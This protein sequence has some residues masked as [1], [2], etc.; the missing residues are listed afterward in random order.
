MLTAAGQRTPRPTTSSPPPWRHVLRTLVVVALLCAGLTATPP[1]PAGASEPARAF[2]HFDG[3]ATGFSW[4]NSYLLALLSKYAYNPDVGAAGN[5]QFEDKFKETVQPLGLCDDLDTCPVDFV[6]EPST[7]TEVVK[8]ETADAVIITFRGTEGWQEGPEDLTDVAVDGNILTT[9]SGIHQGFAD[10]ADSVHAEV[11]AWAAQARADGKRIWL[12]GHSLGG[13]VAEVTGLYLEAPHL[14]Q[15]PS[16]AS[17]IQVQNVYPYGAPRVYSRFPNSTAFNAHVANVPTQRWVNGFDPVPH[18]PPSQLLIP[19]GTLYTHVG[20]NDHAS[21]ITKLNNIFDCT[22]YIDDTELLVGGNPWDHDIGRYSVRIYNLMPPSVRDLEGMPEPP[23]QSESDQVLPCDEDATPPPPQ[24]LRISVSDSKITEGDE[25]TLSVQFLEDEAP[26]SGSP[27]TL[28]LDWGEG[29]IRL[30][31]A[32]GD[33]ELT[34]TYAD[35]AT[36]G[37]SSDAYRIRVWDVTAGSRTETTLV[38]VLNAEPE[39]TSFVTPEAVDEGETFTVSGTFTDVG[40][41]DTHRV[42]LQW[43]DG[44]SEWLT[45]PFGDRTF[46]ASHAYAEGSGGTETVVALVLDDDGDHDPSG[47]VIRV[48]NVA[49][50]IET[51]RLGATTIDEGGTAAIRGTFSDPS[52]LDSHTVSVDWGDGT[53]PTVL[54]VAADADHRQFVARHDYPDD[55]P[56]GTAE[57]VYP[58]TVTVTDDDGGTTSDALDL[59]VAN[60]APSL[61]A[62]LDE[63]TIDEHEVATVRGTVTDAGVADTHR[64]VVDWGD[65]ALGTT[66]VTPGSD[67]SFEASARYGD[68]GTFPVSVTV[69]DDDTG[70]D[71]E[72]LTLTVDNVAPTATIDETGTILGDG[73]DG[74]GVLE[75]PTLV[76]RAGGSTGFS[77]RVTD[78]GSDDLTVTWDWD[79]TDSLD[80]GSSTIVDL[81]APPA[82]DADPSPSVDPRDVGLPVSHTWSAPCLYEVSLTATDDDGG[83]SADSLFVLVTGTADLAR[84]AG[85]WQHQYDEGTQP[86]DDAVDPTT[87]A[88][89]LR[90]VT[91]L[92]SVFGVALPLADATDATSVLTPPR[93]AEPRSLLAREL[94]ATWLNVVNG[95]L[96]WTEQVDSDGDGVTDVVL[97]DLVGAAEEAYVDPATTRAQL[98]ELKD[99]LQHLSPDAEEQ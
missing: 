40:V 19:P 93:P 36:P 61:E 78:P 37:T 21:A 79:P 73:A 94:L 12:N 98:L 83:A 52:P 2:D 95:A 24:V 18:V 8:V 97:A 51:L 38:T 34:H 13:A 60:V 57:D 88:C 15:D 70:T 76:T 75:T 91:H 50:T 28:A 31:S 45:V 96:G 63:R 58:V 85:Y 72:T 47:A 82:T 43:G 44:S 68:D 80:T 66:E 30:L 99:A 6:F 90:T 25:V 87:L 89:H 22:P 92:S 41:E 5:T 4:R 3:D 46:E 9:A 59:T 86:A 32:G 35:D 26:E 1:G 62:S 56:T 33:L 53:A 67:G 71:S 11:R 42:R 27:H 49:P 29:A 74:D 23:Y 81:V 54:E 84:G 48:D 55:D 17:P 20:G 14:R 39:I 65:P 7:D 10:A 77:V 69:T 16:S 64:V